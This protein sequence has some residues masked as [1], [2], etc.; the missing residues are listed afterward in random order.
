[1]SPTANCAA[2]MCIDFYGIEQA[3]G[4]A[5][6][7]RSAAPRLSSPRRAAHRTPSIRSR[8]C[9][10]PGIAPSR[11]L[12][13]NSSF[14]STARS[15]GRSP[16]APR[17]GP[18]NTPCAVSR[19]AGTS[20][21]A[22][23]GRAGG[24]TPDGIPTPN[25][26]SLSTGPEW[27]GPLFRPMALI[28]RTMCQDTHEDLV[29]AW[30]A[31]L[32]APE[33]DRSRALAALQDVRFAGYDRAGGE[34]RAA[35]ASRNQVDEMRVARRLAAEFRRTLRRGRS[36]RARTQ[37]AVTGPVTGGRSPRKTPPCPAP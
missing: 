37:A 25:A 28:I 13:S 21:T 3:G 15:C 32:A 18:G 23:T 9:A 36:A 24:P 5:A 8:C 31:I 16:R 27:T 22:A 29:R 10:A 30:R 4:R 35:L 11:R 33:P 14:P 1:M 26:T 17:A 2:G 34:I 12:S 19:C 7:R 6:T 20:T